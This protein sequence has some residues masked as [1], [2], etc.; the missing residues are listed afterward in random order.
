MASSKKVRPGDRACD[1]NGSETAF[2]QVRYI[3]IKSLL[4]ILAEIEAEAQHKDCPRER[5]YG[6]CNLAADTIRAWLSHRFLN[7]EDKT[8]V[9]SEETLQPRTKI[10]GS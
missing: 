9:L 7:L 2:S 8:P 6:C 3:K 5:G 1:L 10:A 4:K